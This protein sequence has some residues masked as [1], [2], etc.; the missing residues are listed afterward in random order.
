VDVSRGLIEI[1]S[2]HF[3]GGTEE[4]YESSS[5]RISAVSAEI[6][7]SPPEYKST[8]N[9]LVYKWIQYRVNIHVS[10]QFVKW[11]N[12]SIKIGPSFAFMIIPG[13]FLL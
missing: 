8:P 5:V 2:W 4:N 9:H 7:L 6:E 11:E 10:S 13:L 3:Q 12:L 1:F